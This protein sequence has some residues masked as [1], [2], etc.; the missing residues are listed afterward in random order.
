ML[1]LSHNLFVYVLGKRNDT[2][3]KYLRSNLSTNLLLVW[4]F[5]RS[6]CSK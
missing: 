2:S 6:K 1:Y 3:T 5:D 4:N